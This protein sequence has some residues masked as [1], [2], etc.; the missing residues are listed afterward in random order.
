MSPAAG[1][2]VE[3]ALGDELALQWA[4]IDAPAYAPMCACSSC[5]YIYDSPPCMWGLSVRVHKC[6]V[7]VSCA[8]CV[9]H[10]RACACV[11]CEHRAR[12]RARARVRTAAPAFASCLR[13]ACHRSHARQVSALTCRHERGRSAGAAVG[14]G[15]ACCWVGRLWLGRERPAARWGDSS[16][17]MACHSHRQQRPRRPATRT[18]AIG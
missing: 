18:Q 17:G 16:S 3:A 8:C 14:G 4:R 12:V 13:R 11:W 6:C 1:G 7:C 10:A 9:R 5:M 2:H 15:V